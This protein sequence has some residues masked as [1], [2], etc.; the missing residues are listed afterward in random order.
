MKKFHAIFTFDGAD[1]KF[2]EFDHDGDEPSEAEILFRCLSALSSEERYA[3]QKI[4]LTQLE[5]S[6]AD[7][8]IW[9]EADPWGRPRGNGKYYLESYRASES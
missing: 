7:H 8:A 1:Q 3:L 4:S 6:D 5:A 2:L 9:L